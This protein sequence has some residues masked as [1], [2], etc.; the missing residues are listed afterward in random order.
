VQSGS[1]RIL[2]LMR[3]RYNVRILTRCV[4]KIVSRKPGVFLAGDFIVGFPNE[5]EEDFAASGRLAG[6]LGLAALHVFPFSPRPGTAA[7]D[8]TGRLP[9]NVVKHRVGVLI[10][11]GKELMRRYLSD[12][13]G[14]QVDVILEQKIK[15]SLWRGTSA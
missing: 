4:K 1:D 13:K 3:R 15:A 6:D 9:D 8:F 12:W 11:L 7:I 14:K 10:D 2:S 5:S